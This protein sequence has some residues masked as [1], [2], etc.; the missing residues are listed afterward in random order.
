MDKRNIIESDELPKDYEKQPD[1]NEIYIPNQQPNYN[2]YF[3]D[4][5]GGAERE[6]E[7]N[8][9][10]GFLIERLNEREK[11]IVSQY[12]GLNGKKPKTLDEIGKGMGLTKERVRQ[13]NEKALKKL[14][15]EALNNSIT[16]DIYK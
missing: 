1:D 10:V 15:Y 2:D 12:Y 3:I 14:R 7:I 6:K 11:H 9:T 4:E 16:N 8:N 5:G 13:I